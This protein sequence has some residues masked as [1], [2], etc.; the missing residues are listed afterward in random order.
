M[1]CSVC[2]FY[3]NTPICVICNTDYGSQFE[4]KRIRYKRI[5]SYLSPSILFNNEKSYLTMFLESRLL[6][7]TIYMSFFIFLIV[8]FLFFYVAVPCNTD[9][10][11]L[12][13]IL[14]ILS[15][16]GFI[17]YLKSF[18]KTKKLIRKEEIEHL[19]SIKIKDENLYNYYMR[20][21]KLK[22]ILK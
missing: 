3:N 12:L 8:I 7:Y 13:F 10:F 17:V 4:L 19:E 21:K 5:K 15:I 1:Y 22:R 18:K 11:S 14:S 9:P 16:L 6:K 20:R 2:K